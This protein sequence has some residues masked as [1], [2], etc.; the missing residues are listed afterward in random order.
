RDWRATGLFPRSGCCAVLTRQSSG[1]QHQFAQCA[2]P[3]NMLHEK[4][5]IFLWFWFTFLLAMSL[6]S[7]AVWVAWLLPVCP[8]KR[9]VK[10]MIFLSGAPCANPAERR[11]IR[12]FAQDYLRHDGALLISMLSINCGNSVASDICCGLYRKFRSRHEPEGSVTGA[13]TSSA[14]SSARSLSQEESAQPAPVHKRPRKIGFK[15]KRVKWAKLPDR[16]GDDLEDDEESQRDDRRRLF[17]DVSADHFCDCEAQLDCDASADA[18]A[19]R[20]L[21][22]AV[23]I[24]NEA[25]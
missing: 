24:V 7:L 2:L 19:A 6:I 18:P 23:A 1:A 14:A 21:A 16:P 10:R 3:V 11:V 20:T 15:F 8:V 17:K 5:F 25:Q 22:A 9:S 12:S 4:L 13:I